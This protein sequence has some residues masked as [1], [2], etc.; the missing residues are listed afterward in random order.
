MTATLEKQLQQLVGAGLVA[1]DDIVGTLRAWVGKAVA[2]P[3]EAGGVPP[4]YRRA[5]LV[6]LSDA[7]QAGAD[8]LAAR[9]KVVE[10]RNNRRIMAR[11]E[12]AWRIV[13]ASVAGCPV[14]VDAIWKKAE[15]TP[16]E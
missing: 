10:G 9:H 8:H 12:A 15:E 1:E 6:G 14:D 13:A 2:E 16:G 3:V 7:L 4:A 5:I 11:V